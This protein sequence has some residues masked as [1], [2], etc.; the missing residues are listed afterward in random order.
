M[1]YNP[2]NT[3]SQKS[4]KIKND[5][6]ILTSFWSS[7]FYHSHFILFLLLIYFCFLGLHPSHMEATAEGL[8]HSHSNTRSKPHL[9]STLQLMAMPDLLTHWAGSGIELESSWIPAE[10]VS[11][12]LQWE[13]YITP[14]LKTRILKH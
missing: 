5:I 4:I 10:F 11:T 8:H 12:E 1:E 3:E 7:S 6:T 9:W 13:L 14:I 2:K